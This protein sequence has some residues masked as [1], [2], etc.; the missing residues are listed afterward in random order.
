MHEVTQMKNAKN[1]FAMREIQQR[2]VG[3]LKFANG[4]LLAQGSSLATPVIYISVIKM[5]TSGQKIHRWIYSISGFRKYI[6]P[7]YIY[8]VHVYAKC[9]QK[10]K[11]A[12]PHELCKTEIPP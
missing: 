12:K 6:G 11:F 8:S 4:P 9:S 10:S 7:T 1:H 2:H 3:H 5:M